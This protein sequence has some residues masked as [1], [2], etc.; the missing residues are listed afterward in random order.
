MTT[1]PLQPL[2]TLR[3]RLTAWYVVT[4]SGILLLL[5]GGLYFT[6]RYQ[7][8]A[9]LDVS[10]QSATA[11]L[12]RAARIRE[13]EAGARGRVVD[14][15]EELH[16]PD[17]SLFLLDTA[18]SPITPDTAP[19]WVRSAARSVRAASTEQLSRET[20]SEVQLRL[21]AERFVLASGKSMVAV[22]VADQVELE[23]RYAALIAAFG[24]A[25]AVAVVLV[26]LGGSFLVQQSLLPVE[27][28][29]AHMRRFMADAAHEMRTPL[30]VIRS[31][32][33]VALQ[34]P[35]TGGDYVDAIQ[36]IE[37]ETRRLGHIVEDLLTLARADAG[38]RPLVRSRVFLDDIVSDAAGAAGAMANAR[39]VELVIDEF[40]EAPVDGDAALLRQLAML[41]LDNAVKF[42]PAS[43]RVSVRVGMKDGRARLV[44]QDTGPGIPDDQL[45]HIFERFYRGDPARS[46]GNAGSPAD[47]AGLGLAIA[48][49]IIDSHGAEISVRSAV[50][51]GTS[52][53]VAFPEAG[54]TNVSSS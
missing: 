4:L 16:I 37:A 41:L 47:G 49:W 17:R 19:D 50:G 2:R 40:E 34:Q 32:A 39:S 45:A 31:R 30:T 36:G 46:R 15:V 18:G 24:A 20:P 21:H 26:A 44:V 25:A 38:E 1:P 8:S 22:A 54:S 6:I 28:S 12:A 51:A 23:D 43:G 3:R 10:L 33:E 27:R 48:K 11:E 14:A 53:S 52:V 35:R 7:L 5:G 13:L 42:T 9:Q 29:I